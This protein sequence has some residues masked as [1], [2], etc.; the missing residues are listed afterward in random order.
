MQIRPDSEAYLEGR[1]I[2]VLGH[3]RPFVDPIAATLR[4]AGAQVSSASDGAGGLRSIEA[5]KVD[6]VVCDLCL[7]GRPGHR[8]L[9]F[10]GLAKSLPPPSAWGRA[11]R[12]PAGYGEGVISGRVAYLPLPL[13][14]RQL[15]TLV[16]SLTDTPT[17]L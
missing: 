2:L 8:V 6:L 7:S 9:R 15:V 1:S 10:L 11:R 3:P 16:G 4:G 12:S 14:R 13:N 5:A 17:S